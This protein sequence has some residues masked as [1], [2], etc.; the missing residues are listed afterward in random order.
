MK[1]EHKWGNKVEQDNRGRIEVE[2][3]N[4]TREQGE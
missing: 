2:H 4:G 1:V 3:K